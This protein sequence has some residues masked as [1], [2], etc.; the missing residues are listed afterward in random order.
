MI[1]SFIGGGLGFAGGM[2]AAAQGDWAADQAVYVRD[3]NRADS[4]PW[5]GAGAGAVNQIAQLLGLG[6][7]NYT[8]DSRGNQQGSLDGSSA[9]QDRESAFKDFGYDPGYQFRMDQGIKALDRSAASKGMLMSGAQ[10]KGIND[11]GQNQASQEYGNY[12]NRLASLAGAGQSAVA[13]TG[14]IGSSTLAPMVKGS[15]ISAMGR[16]SAYNALGSGISKGIGNFGMLM[17]MGG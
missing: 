5:R 3:Q 17:G 10:A 11:Y 14:Q 12:F 4:S 2:D 6:H 16:Q 8:T 1:G 13:Q 15:E 9:V 7:I